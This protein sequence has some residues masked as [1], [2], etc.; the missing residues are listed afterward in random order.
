[1]LTNLSR[2]GHHQSRAPWDPCRRPTTDQ[3]GPPFQERRHFSPQSQ[4][5][6][7]RLGCRLP[8]VATP[9]TLDRCVAIDCK[10]GPHLPA[11]S[12]DHGESAKLERAVSVWSRRWPTTRRLGSSYDHA[13][14]KLA[15]SHPC[16]SP[17]REPS[18]VGGAL[19]FFGRIFDERM[20]YPLAGLAGSCFC[21]S[22]RRR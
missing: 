13:A 8:H 19:K 1:M 6:L 4:R 11:K 17:C 7:K 15:A 16:R 3:Q 10:S 20:A 21:R 9:A 2:R 14:V 5:I 22:S 12:M 18:V